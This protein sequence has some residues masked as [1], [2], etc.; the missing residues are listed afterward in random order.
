MHRC[1]GTV[2]GDTAA[3]LME[4]L[5]ASFGLTEDESLAKIGT[6]IHYLD[7]GGVPVPEAPGLEALLRGARAALTDDDVLLAEAGRLFEF[8][9]TSYGTRT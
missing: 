7:V 6:I 8:L 3:T 9:Y 1:Y 2:N 4:V 5:L